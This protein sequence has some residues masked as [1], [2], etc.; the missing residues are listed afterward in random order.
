MPKRSRSGSRFSRGKKQTLWTTDI[1]SNDIG[2]TDES[3]AFAIAVGTNWERSATAMEQATVLAIVGE[4]SIYPKDATA[5][6]GHQAITGMFTIQD[7][8]A[9]VVDAG[10]AAQHDDE[11]S[12]YSLRYECHKQTATVDNQ[13]RD[14][15]FQRYPINI[16]TKRRMKNDHQVELALAYD[17]LTGTGS[18][19]RVSWVLRTLIAVG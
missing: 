12:M 8:D 6:V 7:K 2:P 9:P 17:L 18:V 14:G 4:V 16:K 3:A 11:M 19:F 10:I 15:A 1:S 5:A 13:W